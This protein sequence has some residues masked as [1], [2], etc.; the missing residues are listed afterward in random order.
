[1]NVFLV[2][3]L[4]LIKNGVG[5]PAL[6]QQ[7]GCEHHTTSRASP[8]ENV[9]T[10]HIQAQEKPG[11]T[12][13]STQLCTISSCMNINDRGSTAECQDLGSRGASSS[14]D[15]LPTGKTSEL[16]LA[17]FQGWILYFNEQSEGN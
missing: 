15:H 14:C 13:A 6:L 8:T 5:F 3:C 2:S 9:Q 12:N 10:A 16:S 4:F 17:V 7:A 1:M 11:R